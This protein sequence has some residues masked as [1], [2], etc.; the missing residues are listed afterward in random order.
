MVIDSDLPLWVT[1]KHGFIITKTDNSRS[2]VGGRYLHDTVGVDLESDFNLRNTSG[3]W[4]DPGQLEL[5]EEVV[6]LR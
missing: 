1:I 5:S 6:I 3:C 2:L 4:W